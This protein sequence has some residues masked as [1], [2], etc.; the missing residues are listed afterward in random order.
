WGRSE[1]PR[2]G[3]VRLGGLAGV[4]RRRR[5]A[6]FALGRDRAG[7]R[8]GR[9]RRRNGLG[10]RRD[11]GPLGARARRGE[12]PLVDAFLQ[13]LA[14]LEEGQALGAHFDRAARARFTPVV[15]PVA[16]QLEA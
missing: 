15:A 6:G 5:R 13:L 1:S 10:F 2:A 4:G 3:G 8:R 12:A 14:D 11:G 7:R 16:A 9:R